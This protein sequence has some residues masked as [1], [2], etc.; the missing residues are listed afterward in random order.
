MTCISFSAALDRRPLLLLHL[1]Q[2]S[3]MAMTPASKTS[4]PPLTMP[5]VRAALLARSQGAQVSEP[6]VHPETA[7]VNGTV[8]V[9][10]P[11]LEPEV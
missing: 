6:Q 7:V 1:Q 5:P 2:R 3:T 4:T 8:P 11:V 9:E 10:S